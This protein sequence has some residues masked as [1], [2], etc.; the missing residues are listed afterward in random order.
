MHCQILAE[1][2][3]ADANRLQEKF[4]RNARKVDKEI[5]EVLVERM[6]QGKKLN[7]EQEKVFQE[8]ETLFG[9]KQEDWEKLQSPYAGVE[10]EINKKGKDKR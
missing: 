3:L 4:R 10:M 5:R 8:L 9:G 6:K 7:E 1:S 2:E